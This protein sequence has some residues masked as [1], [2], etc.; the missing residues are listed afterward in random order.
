[1]TEIEVNISL[2]F[3]TKR[4]AQIAYE[5]LRVDKEPKR[6]HVRKEFILND[7]NLSV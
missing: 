7:N 4:S 2:E 3:P 5:V 1:M 6:N